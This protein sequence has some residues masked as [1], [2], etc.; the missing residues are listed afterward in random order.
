M[1]T[2]VCATPYASFTSSGELEKRLQG[3]SKL[4]WELPVHCEADRGLERPPSPVGR[5]DH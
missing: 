1:A 5:E 3:V 2:T 4:Y